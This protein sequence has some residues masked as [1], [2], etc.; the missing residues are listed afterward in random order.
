MITAYLRLMTVRFWLT[1]A[2]GTL[3][4]GVLIGVPTDV[5]ANPWF[6]RIVPVRPLDYVIWALT[7]LL[8]G[9]LAATYLLPGAT[10]DRRPGRAGLGAGLLGWLA[11]GCPVCNKVV[12]LLLGSSGALSY[13]AP[14]QPVLG[15]LAV[16]LSATALS[17][18]LRSFIAGCSLPKATMV[19]QAQDE[20]RRVT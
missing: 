9:A 16:V 12:V 11:V 20:S 8:T 14:L 7:S 15:A 5:L 3:A 19:G 2:G 18:R 1:A 10:P 17:V 13:F 6:T 4:A